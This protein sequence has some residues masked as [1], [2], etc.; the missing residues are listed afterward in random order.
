MEAPESLRK[1]RGGDRRAGQ[2]AEHSVT[3]ST[4]A[5]TPG[6]VPAPL[7]YVNWGQ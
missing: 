1:S 3:V 6:G 7:P 5:R 2:P 4:E